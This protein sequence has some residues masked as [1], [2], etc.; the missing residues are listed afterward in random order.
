M[1][2]KEGD[3]TLTFDQPST[4][5]MENLFV[6]TIAD[7]QVNHRIVVEF[8]GDN[9]TLVAWHGYVVQ[10]PTTQFEREIEVTNS[11]DNDPIEVAL[12]GVKTNLETSK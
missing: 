12:E 7:P 9:P 5:E 6:G 1:I 4:N 11:A 8:V 3:L 10:N 2:S